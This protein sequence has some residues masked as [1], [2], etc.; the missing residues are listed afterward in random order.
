MIQRSS[1]P[2]LSSVSLPGSRE[3]TGDDERSCKKDAR[4]STS[5]RM[6]LH[7]GHGMHYQ[8]FEENQGKDCVV[9]TVLHKI[10]SSAQD[11]PCKALEGFA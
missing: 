9:T 10:L 2:S 6:N 8:H 3:D 5:R 7:A 1:R 11:S 4:S